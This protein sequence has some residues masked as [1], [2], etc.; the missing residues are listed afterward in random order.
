MASSE[1]YYDIL[2]VDKSASEADLKKAYRD[3][4]K[5]YHPD[6]NPDNPGAEAKFKEI[7]EAYQVLS[8]SNKRA[9]Y[10]RF[11][12]EAFTSG[13]SAA[14]SGGGF[15]GMGGVN[16]DMGDIFESFFGGD[17]FGGGGRQGPRVHRG[18][19]V[20]T[21]IQIKFEE[22]VFGAEKEISLGMM[23]SCETCG[24]SG[25]KAGTVAENCRHCGG[26]GQE[27]VQQ[28]TMFG[29][30]TNVRTCSVCRGEGKVI[31]EPCSVCS[32]TGRVRKTKKIQFSI[33][34]GI[35]DGMTIRQAGKGQPSE[36]GGP[37][38]DLLITVRVQASKEFKR[39]GMNLY[40]NIPIS[41]T[42]AAL[43]DE[44]LIPTLTE[45]EKYSIKPGT[46]PGTTFIMRGKGVPNVRR[47]NQV[48]D[49]IATFNVVIPKELTKRQKEI[50]QDFAKESGEEITNKK[51]KGIFK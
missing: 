51:K 28:Q 2:G 50:L 5:K 13:G 6:A 46:Q 40:I 33:P 45:P 23:D 1:N 21:T 38:G 32:G 34:K 15:G 36:R 14:G 44:I 31:K 35:D 49:I 11:G 20:S 22:A 47:Q 39:D 9:Q 16:F 24:G 10:D 8:D 3:L 17:I 48:G 27:R 30:M 37:A 43:G 42:Q 29:T 41:I 4:V 12:H 18:Q 7:N 26:T 19:D 25:A